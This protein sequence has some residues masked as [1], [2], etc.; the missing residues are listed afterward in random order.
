M[1]AGLGRSPEGGH[2]NPIQHLYLENP[3]RQRGLVGYSPWGCKESDTTE[4]LSTV[5]HR[6]QKNTKKVSVSKKYKIL[7]NEI[8]KT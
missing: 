8:K 7:M 5:K 2:G 4:E 6:K 1:I 3:H